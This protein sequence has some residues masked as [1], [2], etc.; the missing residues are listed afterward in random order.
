MKVV[1]TPKNEQ[2]A[3][4]E[5]KTPSIEEVDIAKEEPEFNG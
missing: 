1:D 5:A 4:V 3:P 2:K